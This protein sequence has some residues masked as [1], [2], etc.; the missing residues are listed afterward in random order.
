MELLSPDAGPRAAMAAWD[1]LAPLWH[2]H[3]R[4]LT[5]L[6]IGLFLAGAALIGFL[7]IRLP[8]DYFVPR[9][10]APRPS[11][12]HPLA[13]I[14]LAALRNTFG[15]AL[16]L[17]G[18]LMSA[19]LVPGPGLLAILLGLS[20]MS[21]PGKRRLERRLLRLPGLL[22]SI[23]ALRRRFHRAPIV[24]PAPGPHAPGPAVRGGGEN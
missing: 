7:I 16:V 18:V 11:S 3:G 5:A 12:R 9:A 14:I 10:N 4:W 6:S 17:L 13:R 23:N 1:A 20:L 8:A 22:T 15:F 2:A 19:P 21:F 24:V